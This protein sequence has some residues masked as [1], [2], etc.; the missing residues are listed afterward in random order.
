M[1]PLRARSGDERA[2][3]SA[4]TVRPELVVAL[5]TVAALAVRVVFL[6]RTVDIPGDGPMRAMYGYAWAVDPYIPRWGWWPPGPLFMSGVVNLVVPAPLYVTRVLDIVLGTLTVPVLYLLVR[7]TFGEAPALFGAA[8]VAFLPIH[9]ELSAS[10]FTEAAFT[11]EIVAGLLLVIAAFDGPLVRRLPFALGLLCLVWAAMTRYEVWPLLLLVPI[12]VYWRSRSL[13]LAIVA[14]GVLAA[15]P[16]AWMLGNI[17]EVGNPL[18]G[19]AHQT[20]GAL[21]QGEHAIPLGDGLSLLA[22]T[23]IAEVGWPLALAVA[24]GV[25]T[26][27]AGRVPTAERAARALYLATVTLFVITMSYMAMVRGGSFYARFLLLGLVLMLPWAMLPLATMVRVGG[28]AWIAV[29]LVALV[30]LLSTGRYTKSTYVTYRRP[31]EIQELAHWLAA[32]SYRNEFVLMTDLA[33]DSSYLG[34]YWPDVVLHQEIVSAWMEDADLLKVLRQRRP[35][36]LV[37]RPEDAEQQER[38]ARTVGAPIASAPKIHTIG[39]LE[40]YDIRALVAPLTRGQ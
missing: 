10:S 24:A 2:R 29:V 5:L 8:V 1:T 28:R 9:V 7:R 27:C 3:L 31:T 40:I 23:S 12:Y 17:H 36:L 32:S 14:A 11:F 25:V 33:W 21:M 20:K 39:T 6:L 34:L 26:I 37:T 15:F 4:A 35:V 22:R 19:L 16:C 13:G 30:S 38:I 18:P